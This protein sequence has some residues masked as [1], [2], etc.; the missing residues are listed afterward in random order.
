MRSKE[1]QKLGGELVELLTPSHQKSLERPELPH[2]QHTVWDDGEV[3]LP[4]SI[5]M[6]SICSHSIKDNKKQKSH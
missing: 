1:H 5:S 4:S 2:P 6:T 3:W